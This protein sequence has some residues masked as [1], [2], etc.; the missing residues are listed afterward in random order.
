MHSKHTGAIPVP[1]Y[2]QLQQRCQH[3]HYPPGNSR[4]AQV[5]TGLLAR[6]RSSSSAQCSRGGA[7]NTPPF[8]LLGA[9]PW[10]LAYR[11]PRLVHLSLQERVVPYHVHLG[12]ICGR[13]RHGYLGNSKAD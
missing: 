4:L 5:K 12:S 6:S 1:L 10:R 11:L 3:S 7:G 13:C 9:L 2:P 8:C